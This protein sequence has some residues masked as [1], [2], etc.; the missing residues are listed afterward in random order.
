MDRLPDLQVEGEGYNRLMVKAIWH[1]VILAESGQ[2]ILVEGHHYFPP[3]SV[4]WDYFRESQ[5]HTACAWK[6][7]A[8]YY[9]IH[10]GDQVNKDAAWFYPAPSPVV[11][12]IKDHVA[13]WRGVQVFQ[14]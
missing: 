10:V 3:E 12:Q 8:S 11:R 5:T 6:G 4:R 13:F 1:D 9:D 7:I 2:T 14:E